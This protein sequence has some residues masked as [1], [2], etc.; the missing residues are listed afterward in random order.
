MSSVHLS[1]QKSELETFFWDMKDLSRIC[2]SFTSILVPLAHSRLFQYRI[3][4]H[5]LTKIRINQVGKMYKCVALLACWYLNINHTYYFTKIVNKINTT[6]L[7]YRKLK[8]IQLAGHTSEPHTQHT[9]KMRI[10]SANIKWIHL[11]CEIASNFNRFI[12]RKWE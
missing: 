6:K 9:Y 12:L 10:V 4:L 1:P 8:S 3:W 11:F 7:V 2:Q 5:I